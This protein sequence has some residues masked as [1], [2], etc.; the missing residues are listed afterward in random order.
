MLL[1][2]GCLC[3]LVRIYISLYEFR[4]EVQRYFNRSNSCNELDIFKIF[5][6]WF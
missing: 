1:D 2:F 5:P 4:C 3:R 6:E